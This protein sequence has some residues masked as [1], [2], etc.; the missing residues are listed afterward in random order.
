MPGPRERRYREEWF[1]CYPARA[2]SIL[3]P[4][5]PV[6]FAIVGRSRRSDHRAREHATSAPHSTTLILWRWQ[7]RS[8]PTAKRAAVQAAV[9]DATAG[10]PPR[11]GLLHGPR[12][13]RIA[14]RAGISRTAFYF[15]FRDKREL[16]SG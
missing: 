1:A 6:A 5:E 2:G 3:R 14:T 4:S 12:L 13:E 16:L 9:L 10:A 8:A 11:G 15:Y 7:S